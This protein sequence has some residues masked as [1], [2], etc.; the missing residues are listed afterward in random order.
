VRDATFIIPVYAVPE[1]EY[2]LT[3]NMPYC[4]CKR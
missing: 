4:Y 3:V 1:V 2:F